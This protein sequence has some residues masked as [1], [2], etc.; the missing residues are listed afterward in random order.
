MATAQT[1]AEA[2]APTP[3]D[4]AAL[5][6]LLKIG[7]PP[8][9]PQLLATLPPVLQLIHKLLTSSYTCAARTLVREEKNKVSN[10]HGSA[11]NLTVYLERDELNSPAIE[12][13]IAAFTNTTFTM[14]GWSS[15]FAFSLAADKGLWATF[16]ANTVPAKEDTTLSTNMEVLEVQGAKYVLTYKPFT[17]TP[18]ADPFKLNAADEAYF[19]ACMTRL[20][21]LSIAP[22]VEFNNNASDGDVANHN[23]A[24]MKRAGDYY[25]AFLLYVL[26]T[27]LEATPHD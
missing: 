16:V 9:F 4:T 5:P 22:V 26:R 20:M 18:P 14:K 1:K 24:G 19:L 7:E 11:T 25:R 2:S 27:Y 15:D 23:A 6:A 8:L 21:E 13:L 10:F 12:P 3:F 17:A